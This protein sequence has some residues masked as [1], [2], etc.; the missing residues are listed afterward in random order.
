DVGRGRGYVAARLD[1]PE[2][3]STEHREML[4]AA[5]E[6]PSRS[7][8]ARELLDW[9]D[10][11]V[12]RQTQLAEEGQML[13]KEGEALTAEKRRLA[14]MNEASAEYRTAKEAYDKKR[15]AL[16]EKLAANA[17]AL[18]KVR[19]EAAEETK[20]E[21][22][23]S[24]T[25]ELLEDELGVE[26]WR[27]APMLEV[28]LPS[29]LRALHGRLG[30]EGLNDLSDHEAGE[31][32]IRLWALI[33][34][35]PS[36]Q[37]ALIQILQYQGAN[38]KAFKD[39]Q[40][41]GLL[42][43][44]AKMIETYPGEW[45]GTHLAEVHQAVMRGDIAGAV[46][47]VKKRMAH[48]YVT[49]GEGVPRATAEKIIQEAKEGTFRGM[50]E[51]HGDDRHKFPQADMEEIIKNPDAVYFNGEVLIFRKGGDI[52]ILRGPGQ[53]EGHIVTAYGPSGEMGKSGVAAWG[54]Q[55]KETDKGLPIT[56]DM[57]VNGGIPTGK[58]LDNGDK[59]YF[60][61]AKQVFP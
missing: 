31:A 29:Q 22:L 14:N 46:D 11:L 55:Y 9:L 6:N 3:L 13:A 35:D 25:S 12:A 45:S 57:I 20:M 54:D 34:S 47:L 19:A 44:L 24:L 4:D 58:T 15:L 5:L 17:K 53:R 30:S 60:R 39:A 48:L 61:G 38:R 10:P 40:L 18:A 23:R 49:V 50:K 42:S 26:W 51:Y 16:D 36:G 56:H 52:V 41:K 32:F 8:R 1:D 59:Q 27:L 21:E 2:T 7:D 28:M 43:E 33:G 37:S